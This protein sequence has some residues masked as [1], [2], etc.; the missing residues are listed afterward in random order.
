MAIDDIMP[1]DGPKVI[2]LDIDEVL[3]FTRVR[4]AMPGG[5]D[6]DPVSAALL[7]RICVTTGARIVVSSTWRCSPVRCKRMFDAHG[8]T[9]HLWSPIVLPADDPDDVDDLRDHASHDDDRDAWRTQGQNASRKDAIDAWLDLH[10]QVRTWI[11]LDDSKQDFDQRQLDRLIHTD[12]M[13]GISMGDYARSIRLLTGRVVLGT[14]GFQTDYQPPRHT[15]SKL[16]SDALAAID[17]GDD[18]AVQRLLAIIRDHPL[19]Q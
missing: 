7:V 12:V 2:F 13:F 6:I 9:P 1:D 3:L 19:S 18:D 11:I 10:P 4:L 14:T 15:I 8:I 16:A 5:D 17:Q